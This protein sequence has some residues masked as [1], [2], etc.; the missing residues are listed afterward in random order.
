[1][2]FTVGVSDGLNYKFHCSFHVFTV[3][4]I[5]HDLSLDDKP[6]VTTGMAGSPWAQLYTLQL[7]PGLL[8]EA[9]SDCL[10][11]FK[12]ITDGTRQTELFAILAAHVFETARRTPSFPCTWCYLCPIVVF[13]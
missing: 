10:P 7:A 2:A 4:C 5:N 13:T 9:I 12:R 8:A 6:G 1:M 3:D 11:A